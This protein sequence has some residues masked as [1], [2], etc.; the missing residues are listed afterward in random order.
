M[1]PNRTLLVLLISTLALAAVG[2]SVQG[3]E[4]IASALLP[5]ACVGFVVAVSRVL[6]WARATLSLLVLAA[7]M[8]RYV[9][10]VGGLNLKAEHVAVAIAVVVLIWSWAVRGRSVVS[11]R[12]SVVGMANVLLGAW[13][14][15]N[16]LGSINA[17]VPMGSLKLT[18]QLAILFAGYIVVQHFTRRRADL[19]L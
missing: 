12:W 6:G 5:A 18:F 1:K 19:Y 15:A 17:P 8:N 11:G 14:L 7:L 10:S 13:V 2:F 16:G 3:A 9:V 4:G